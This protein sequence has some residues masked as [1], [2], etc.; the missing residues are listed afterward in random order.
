MSENILTTERNILLS[1]YSNGSLYHGGYLIAL[2]LGV[3]GV[4]QLQSKYLTPL[5]PI[6]FAVLVPTAIHLVGR[7]M[8]W[9]YLTSAVISISP[10]A[11]KTITNQAVESHFPCYIL[12]VASIYKLNIS[13]G[14]SSTRFMYKSFSLCF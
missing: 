13:S 12:I 6:V 9:G 8:Y 1:Y 10:D 5:F 3:V 11:I 7:T 4:F 14:A 2:M